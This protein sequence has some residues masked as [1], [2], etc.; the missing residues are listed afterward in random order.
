MQF[1]CTATAM[2][3]MGDL[4]EKKNDSVL[5]NSF[6]SHTTELGLSYGTQEEFDF[7]FQIY[8]QKDAEI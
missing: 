6:V 4:C 1:L 3:G 8:A 5:M 7:R 2:L